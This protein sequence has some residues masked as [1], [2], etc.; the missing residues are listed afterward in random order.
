MARAVRLHRKG[1]GFESL[2]AHSMNFSED[3]FLGNLDRKLKKENRVSQEKIDAFF[4]DSNKVKQLLERAERKVFLYRPS[5][6][7]ST[8]LSSQEE[9][10]EHKERL[11][12]A[13]DS[14][15]ELTPEEKEFERIT[16][17]YEA[18]VIDLLSS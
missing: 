8:G 15:A 2:I 18:V 7:E 5:L 9:I 3:R 17:L 1:R 13:K 10:T 14:F 12:K 11:R 16:K 4:A 6:E